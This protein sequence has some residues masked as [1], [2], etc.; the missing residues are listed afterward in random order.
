[1]AP[2]VE[3]L[4]GIETEASVG[5]WPA[6]Q[7]VCPHTRLGHDFAPQKFAG[8]LSCPRRQ[9]ANKSAIR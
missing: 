7:R 6:R 9:A 4:G 8:A 2:L 3:T 1:M 5:C